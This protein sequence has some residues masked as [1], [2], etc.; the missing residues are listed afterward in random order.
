MDGNGAIVVFDVG[1]VLTASSRLYILLLS[2][3]VKI[4]NERRNQDLI[5]RV[6]YGWDIV[7]FFPDGPETWSGV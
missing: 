6:H 4:S 7:V 1:R 5:S 2:N 3:L